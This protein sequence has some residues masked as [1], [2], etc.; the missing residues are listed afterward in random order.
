MAKEQVC[1]LICDLTMSAMLL[2][3]F[4]VFLC[5]LMESKCATWITTGSCCYLP[6]VRN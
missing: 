3:Y 1:T 4:D 6:R 2:E 5:F